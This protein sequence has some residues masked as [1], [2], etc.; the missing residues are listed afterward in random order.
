M[1]KVALFT[2][3]RADYGLLKGLMAAI[4]DDDTLDLQVIAAAGH[5]VARLGETWREITGDG[6]E[7]A[8]R[9]EM[10]D[11]TNT[12]AGV[13]RSMGHGVLAMTDALEHLTPDMLVI[14]GDR[15]EALV[16]AQVAM[17]L[18]I[19]IAH[20]HGGEITEGAIDDAI[21]HAITKMAHLHFVAA[22]AYG[23]RVIQMG[24]PRDRVF[25]VG[26][27]G[28]DSVLARKNAPLQGVTDRFGFELKAPYILAT[29][30][31][32]TAAN[33]DPIA[34][35]QAMLDALDSVP[36]H[37]IVLTFANADHGGHKINEMVE[38]FA[39]ARP[40]RVLA[41]PSLGFELYG[42]V[43]SQATAVVGNS[44]S[45][46]IEAPAFGVPTLNIGTRQSGRL[47]AKSIRTVAAT[48]NGI[49]DGLGWAL[50]KVGQDQSAG[51]TS[52]Y[53]QG[54]AA[55]KI[56]DILKSAPLTGGLPFCDLD[57]QVHP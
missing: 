18:G 46:I 34:T 2:G 25:V 27:P 12:P 36:D 48:K 11:D 13:A 28:L 21:R 40:G 3:T 19:P 30:H 15:A 49:T 29:Y 41:V 42:A 56:L 35:V 54:Q 5:F 37:Q 20:I 10:P 53:G 1:R 33:E 57:L 51:A 7:I 22:E 8:A 17:V 52:L 16:A 31:P 6:F 50:S 32:A 4:Q 47:M 43:L 14:L 55:P 45:G 24:T 23:D 9:V 39:A 44:S 26:A 38:F